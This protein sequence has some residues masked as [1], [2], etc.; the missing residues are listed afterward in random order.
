[1]ITNVTTG[2]TAAITPL[3]KEGP[4]KA[5]TM[6]TVVAA[7]TG[8]SLSG[9]AGDTTKT[10]TL[11]NGTA[12]TFESDGKQVYVKGAVAVSYLYPE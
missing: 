11:P 6:V 7:N 4:P 1:M 2:D 9:I 5:G 3:F 8:C 10:C 12:F